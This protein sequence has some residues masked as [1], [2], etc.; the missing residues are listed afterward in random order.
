MI[1]ERQNIGATLAERRNSELENIQPEIK[2]LAESAGLH[3]GGKI[4]VGER[5]EARFDAQGFRA[6]E[7]FER[8]LLQ[9]AQELAL[10]SGRERSDFIENDGAAAAELEASEFA[11]DRAGKSAAFVAK[12]FAFDKLRRK[13][14]AVDFQEWRVAARAEFMNQAREVVLTAT[15]F[16]G[17]QQSGGS[18]RDFPGEFKKTERC[19]IG[20]DPRQSFRGHGRERPLCGRR[21]AASPEKCLCPKGESGVFRPEEGPSGW[22]GSS[23]LGAMRQRRSRS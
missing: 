23:S 21:E 10:R 6:A 15:A 11:L 7:P 9:N 2:I 19:G 17:D 22:P 3:G 12:E 13:A 5:D 20:G 14:G 1:G 18:D 4:N 16:T 8:A